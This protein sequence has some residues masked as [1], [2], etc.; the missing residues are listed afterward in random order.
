MG[1]LCLVR[2]GQASFGS[3]DYDRLSATGVRQCELLGAYLHAR[4]RC[5]EAVLRGS[6][7]RHQQSLA[8]IAS[9]LPG[10][11]PEIEWPGLNE[12]DGEALVRAV[13]DID[14]DPMPSPHTP[15]GYRQHFRVLREGLAQWMAGQVQ[16][17]G[18]PSWP[19]FV[20][21]V[22]NALD[23]VRS[24][25]EGDVL[26]VSSGGPIATAVAQVLAAPPATVIELNLRLRNSALTEFSFTPKRH[27]LLTFNTLPHLDAPEHAALVSFA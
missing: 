8:A 12:Y 22:S 6:L 26:M 5:F 3:E 7:R 10:L 13:R 2:H 25:F 15:D 17:S 21:G 20:A 18:M 11:P 14:R 9:A 24:N 4:G 16:P 1:T 27:M 23:H 19:G